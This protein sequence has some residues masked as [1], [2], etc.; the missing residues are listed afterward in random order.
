MIVRAGKFVMMC[1]TALI[2]ND[3]RHISKIKVVIIRDE[4]ELRMVLDYL[5]RIE[6]LIQ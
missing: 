6:E 2:A 1:L 5:K 3:A 4:K